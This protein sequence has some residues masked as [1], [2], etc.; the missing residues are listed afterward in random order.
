[1]TKDFVLPLRLDANQNK[2]LE[3]LAH[4]H[5]MSKAEYLRYLLDNASTPEGLKKECK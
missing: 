5:W 1:M 4:E 3:H 2:K